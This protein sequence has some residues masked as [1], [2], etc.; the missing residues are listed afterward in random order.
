MLTKAKG[1]G[2]A[3]LQVHGLF[4]L[5]SCLTLWRLCTWHH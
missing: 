1:G 4:P 5:F 2:K 3:F